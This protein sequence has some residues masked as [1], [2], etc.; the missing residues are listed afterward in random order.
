MFSMDAAV[1]ILS[2]GGLF[3]NSKPHTI[4]HN[5]V[6]SYQIPTYQSSSYYEIGA[7]Q[8]FQSRTYVPPPSTNKPLFVGPPQPFLT[9]YAPPSYQSFVPP[10][11]QPS[12]TYRSQQFQSNS[13]FPPL[14]K[15]V[16]QPLF[17]TPTTQTQFFTSRNQYNSDLTSHQQLQPKFNQ[18]TQ[19]HYQSYVPPKQQASIQQSFVPSSSRPNLFQVTPF[20][21][22][23]SFHN[24]PI[25]QS[26]VP[27]QAMYRTGENLSSN[28]P[29]ISTTSSSRIVQKLSSPGSLM[30]IEDAKMRVAIQSALNQFL[31][32]FRYPETDQNITLLFNIWDHLFN[33]QTSAV[34]ES[35]F[36]SKSEKYFPPIRQ[37]EKSDIFAYLCLGTIKRSQEFK[38]SPSKLKSS[39]QLTKEQFADCLMLLPRTG[40]L[41]T[42]ADAN[43]SKSRVTQSLSK[44]SNIPDFGLTGF[45]SGK[46]IQAMCGAPYLEL[47]IIDAVLLH[48]K[49]DNEG[50]YELAKIC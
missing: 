39:M 4:N 13:M 29:A 19:R 47:K 46:E 6:H 17:T 40:I 35:Q 31:H 5:T 15:N 43:I 8:T 2:T 16:I 45:I 28:L 49:V 18:P 37:H 9:S 50:W 20:Q 32:S 14:F 33:S 23:L 3:A 22:N 30:S 36:F 42:V 27:Q 24:Q 38:N 7:H 44:D 21:T 34:T 11:S 48:A 26:Y 25:S 41:G 1:E 10:P 12:M